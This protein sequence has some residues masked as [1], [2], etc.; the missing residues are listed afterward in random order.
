L[1]STWRDALAVTS[2][3]DAGLRRLDAERPVVI[4]EDDEDHRTLLGDALRGKG[5][6]VVEL[7]NGGEA[8]EHLLTHPEPRAIILDIDL[9]RVSGWGVLWAMRAYARLRR[10]PVI[11]V[12]GDAVA[13][14]PDQNIVARFTKPFRIAEV[15]AILRQCPGGPTG[16]SP[17]DPTG[18]HAP[19]Q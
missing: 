10:I 14:A 18:P 7:A 2:F 11:V 19:A 8:I 13:L 4:V 6:S 17:T 12:S 1:N 5:F 16:E 15:C 3:T 9:P